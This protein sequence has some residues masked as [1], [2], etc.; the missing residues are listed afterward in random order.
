MTGYLEAIKTAVVFFPFIAFLITIP[1]MVYQYHKYGSIPGVRTIIVYSFILYVMTA[2]FLVI[3]PLPSFEEVMRLKT[4]STQLI[5]FS[6]VADFITHTSFNI[7]VPQTY[8]KALTEPY[9]YQVL[10]NILLTIPFGI[11]LRYYFKCNFKKT[12]LFT[13]CLTLFFEITQLTGLYGIY[14]R[15]YRLF[16]VDDLMLNTLGGLIGYFIAGAMLKWIPGR[17]AIDEYAYKNG[18]KISFLRRLTTFGFDAMLYLI[19]TLGYMITAGGDYAFLVMGIIYYGIIPL[20]LEGQTIGEKFFHIKIVP[21]TPSKL[22]WFQVMARRILFFFLYIS[23]PFLFMIGF[24]YII[25][26]FHLPE[27]FIFALACSVLLFII[28]FEVYSFVVIAILKRPLL[29]EQITKTKLVSTITYE[30]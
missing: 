21:F 18:K 3:L 24:F 6:F 19:F 20:C 1:Y 14:P 9:I 28:I 27:Y 7:M 13:F 5:P 11:Y 8:L 30:E 10:Y 2:Y 22:E 23:L 17:D 29:H 12:M 15:S 26:F 4:P 25:E 16:D